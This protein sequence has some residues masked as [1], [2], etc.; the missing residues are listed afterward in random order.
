MVDPRRDVFFAVRT[1]GGETFECVEAEDAIVADVKARLAERIGE[2]ASAGT[3]QLLLWGS[4]LDDAAT[5][6]DS[7]V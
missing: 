6:V 3:L 5:L 1:L 4:E 2:G 7:Q